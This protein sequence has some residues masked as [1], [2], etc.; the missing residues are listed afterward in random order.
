MK[1]NS[2]LVNNLGHAA[3]L[4]LVAGMAAFTTGCRTVNI[5]VSPTAR[6]RDASG[7][8]L[9]LSVGLMLD[10]RFCTNRFLI[11]DSGS[12]YP[13]GPTLKQ[14]SMSLCE[15][16]FERV[17]VSTDGVVP[18]GVD[19]T[20]TPYMHRCGIGLGYGGRKPDITLLL[21][22]TLRTADNRNILW[23]TTV[24][25]RGH[26]SEPK[27]YQLVFD[28]LA[29]KSYRAFQE[30]P[31]IKWLIAKKAGSATSAANGSHE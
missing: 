3:M 31:Q 20:L 27:V 15:Q 4:F 16:S 29:T 26:Q 5:K 7:K 6:I 24:D 10:D 18:A 11:R 9:A 25:G 14:Q 8:K 30:S 12:I 22:W 23:M 17:I 28:D 1:R 21:Q 2:T 13:F 19:V